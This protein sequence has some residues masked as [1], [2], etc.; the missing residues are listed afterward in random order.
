MWA[1]D[2]EFAMVG[3]SKADLFAVES[4]QEVSEHGLRGD[5]SK[6]SR[7]SLQEVQRCGSGKSRDPTR[8]AVVLFSNQQEVHPRL[9][10][11][12]Q[13][14]AT[15]VVK[16]KANDNP[17][18]VVPGTLDWE[19]DPR[20]KDRQVQPHSRLPS[21]LQHLSAP[22]CSFWGAMWSVPQRVACRKRCSRGVQGSRGPI[23]G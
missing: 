21:L 3:G 15:M 6:L 10:T 4:R 20:K 18:L 14:T 8:T 16:Q 9:T 1:P 11:G 12:L 13:Q 2:H 19:L 7:R 5:R 23:S 17:V 22:P